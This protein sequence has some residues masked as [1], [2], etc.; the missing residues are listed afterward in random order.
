[1]S[2]TRK[3]LAILGA[4]LSAILLVGAA[5]G[6]ALG[7]L[8]PIIPRFSSQQSAS[9]VQE[10]AQLNSSLYCPT[11]MKLADTENYGDADFQASEGNL[12]STS[13]ISAM[14]A[15]YQADVADVAQTTTTSIIGDAHMAND[16][17]RTSTDDAGQSLVVQTRTLNAQKFTGAQGTVVSWASEA[18]LRG[19]SAS[20]CVPFATTQSFIVPATSTGWSQQ[21]VVANSSEKSASISLTAHGTQSSDPLTFETH[22]TATVAA[23]AEVTIDL[24]AA[25]NVNDA[26]YVT[27]ESDSAPVAAIVQVV[28]MDGLTPQGSDYSNPLDSADTTQVIPALSDASSMDIAVYGTEDGSAQ[29]VFLGDNGEITTQK[30]SYTAEKLSFTH[31]DN[32]PQ[33]T[34]SVLVTSSSPVSASAISSVSASDGQSDFAVTQARSAGQSFAVNVPENVNNRVDISN[35]SSDTQKVHIAAFSADGS[36]SGERDVEINAHSVYTFAATDISSNATVVQ[37]SQTDSSRASLVVGESFTVNSVSDAQVAQRAS[38][39]TPA[40]DLTTTKYTVTREKT[41]LN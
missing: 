9:S 8:N 39:A 7:W 41:I 10:V 17:V 2:V 3:I 12:S 14:G 28:H 35:M 23:H 32:I 31:V 6:L 19:I 24:S 5:V 18:D 15:V 29:F 34:Q 36:V 11:R 22:A 13:R 26:A 16:S 30:V 20:S 33:G 21:M 37:I 1:M 40:M 27:V 25:F 4:V 38:L